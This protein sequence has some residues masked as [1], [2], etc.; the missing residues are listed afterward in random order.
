VILRLC[1][2]EGRGVCT[3]IGTGIGTSVQTFIRH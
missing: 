3:G 2:V 1:T